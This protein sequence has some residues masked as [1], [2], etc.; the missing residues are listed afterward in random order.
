[1]QV[2]PGG[3]PENMPKEMDHTP[4]RLNISG[5]DIGGVIASKGHDLPD[6]RTIFGPVYQDMGSG[7]LFENH[8]HAA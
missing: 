3:F 6:S 8:G 7:V 1:M 4:C 5:I 2:K